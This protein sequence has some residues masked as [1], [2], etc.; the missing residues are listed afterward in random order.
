MDA[1]GLQDR[2]RITV[3]LPEE[4]KRLIEALRQELGR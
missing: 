2:L 1:F 3:G 4:N